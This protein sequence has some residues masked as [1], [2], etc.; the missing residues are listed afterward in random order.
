MGFS[1][2]TLSAWIASSL[3]VLLRA[4]TQNSACL[5]RLKNAYWQKSF[6]RIWPK[7]PRGCC[8]P[9]GFKIHSFDFNSVAWWLGKDVTKLASRVSAWKLAA[10][11]IR[12]SKSCS[13]SSH[14]HVDMR[15]CS[16]VKV[17]RLLLQ[18]SSSKLWSFSLPE[19][20]LEVSS[21][22]SILH[23]CRAML[24]ALSKPNMSTR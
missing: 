14:L 19:V 22:L 12:C 21:N 1:T 24:S 16:V 3:Y 20:I 11:M 5:P 18:I 8:Y 4:L 6:L 17:F 15:V 13:D 7:G 10:L 23:S 2:R 9:K